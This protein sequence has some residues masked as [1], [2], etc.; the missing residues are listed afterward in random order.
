MNPDISIRAQ[1][2][3]ITKPWSRNNRTSAGLAFALRDPS[4]FQSINLN[5][6]AILHDNLHMSELEVAE[7]VTNLRQYEFFRVNRPV[8]DGISSVGIA[9][10]YHGITHSRNV[11]QKTTRKTED[12]ILNTKPGSAIAP[13]PIRRQPRHVLRTQVRAYLLP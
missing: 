11:L 13:S 10:L 5:D 12:A 1:R 4:S 7:R 9:S 8:S 6:D 2:R 3:E